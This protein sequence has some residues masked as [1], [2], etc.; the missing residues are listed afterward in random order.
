MRTN[1]CTKHMNS[2][3]LHLTMKTFLNFLATF[4]VAAWL[5][6]GHA[7]SVI[8][9]N[10]TFDAAYLSG[11]DSDDARLVSAQSLTN[12]A[13]WFVSYPAGGESSTANVLFSSTTNRGMTLR[14]TDD[15][16]DVNVMAYFTEDR[17]SFQ[18][19]N[20]GDS[21]SLTF[22]LT[23]VN[24][25]NSYRDLVFGLMNSGGNQLEQGYYTTNE[26]KEAVAPFSGYF[27]MTQPGDS[28]SEWSTVPGFR[29]AQT[30]SDNFSLYAGAFISDPIGGDD[31]IW[32]GANHDV[33][34]NLG[35]AVTYDGALT[36][37]RT[38]AE[39]N[40]IQFSLNGVEIDVLHTEATLFAFDTINI[41]YPGTPPAGGDSMTFNNIKLVYNAIPEPSTLALAI[42][43]LWPLLHFV[44]RRK[45]LDAP[46][47][48]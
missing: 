24:P 6:S 22:T 20:I 7:D 25:A 45:P 5:P 35:N 43:A 16:G 15:T 32:A 1:Y 36:I 23:V 34:L 39:E 30:G 17:S 28:T 38:G 2:K 29:S 37:T 13:N 21:L 48:W 27:I 47:V 4:A 19:L 41:G 18:S 9:L 46:R 42:L 12:S 8:L 31:P 44:R 11:G 33:A 3:T 40:R 10:D 26:K 14:K